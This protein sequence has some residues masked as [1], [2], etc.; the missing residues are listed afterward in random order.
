VKNCYRPALSHRYSSADGSVVLSVYRHYRSNRRHRG[1]V[2]F[3]D[4]AKKKGRNL[5]TVCDCLFVRTSGENDD[6][7]DDDD[8][9]DDDD[10]DDDND[11]K[12]SERL[13]TMMRTT[14]AKR[15]EKRTRGSD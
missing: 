1:L 4:P 7:A 3:F 11:D 10:H 6:D 9:Y 8:D 2:F 15:G 5:L 12:S 13:L 14:K